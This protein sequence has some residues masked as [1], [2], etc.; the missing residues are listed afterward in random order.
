MVVR[1]VWS[2]D[3]YCCVVFSGSAMVLQLLATGSTCDA[4]EYELELDYVWWDVDS[5]CGVLYVL[6][7]ACVYRA[8]GVGEEG[9]IVIV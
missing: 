7:P 2:A 8:G 4:T 9:F 5:V 6:G 1:E 3:Q